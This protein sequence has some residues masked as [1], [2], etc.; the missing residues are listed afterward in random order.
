M[1]A[2][3]VSTSLARPRMRSRPSPVAPTGVRLHVQL[4]REL[5]VV[6]ELY[7]TLPLPVV[8]EP[9]QLNAQRRR[10]LLD[11]RPLYS[12]NLGIAV[13]GKWSDNQSSAANAY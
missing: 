3:A 9:L 6:V 11:T 8:V 7:C 5:E 12:V 1:L 13:Q 4:A 10:Q 2:A